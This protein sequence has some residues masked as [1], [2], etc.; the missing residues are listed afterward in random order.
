MQQRPS[1]LVALFAIGLVAC[2]GPATSQP[3]DSTQDAASS[4]AAAG[5]ESQP[6]TGVCRAF[7]IN[8]PIDLGREVIAQ[9]SSGEDTETLIRDMLLAYEDVASDLPGDGQGVADFRA[10]LAR[11]NTGEPWEGAMNEFVGSHAETCGVEIVR[12]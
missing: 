2:G 11:V 5:S 9:E 10:L 8:G 12:H 3:A 1:L 6:A 7:L 4:S